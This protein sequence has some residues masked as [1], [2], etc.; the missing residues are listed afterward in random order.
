MIV[1]LLVSEKRVSQFCFLPIWEQGEPKQGKGIKQGEQAGLA[2]RWVRVGE[3][4]Q[5]RASEIRASKARRARKARLQARAQ[6]R[7]A[8]VRLA[9]IVQGQMRKVQ[10][11]V[12]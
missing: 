4:G 8:Q 1:T 3:D 10:G 12:R 9:R 6:A 5:G 2:S 11:Q 7:Q